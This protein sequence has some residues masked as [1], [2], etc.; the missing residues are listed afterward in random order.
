MPRIA[1]PRNG[2]QRGNERQHGR[3]VQLHGPL[4]QGGG[5]GAPAQDHFRERPQVRLDHDVG[6][7]AGILDADLDLLR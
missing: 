2:G 5:E 4:P 6:F 7:K 3:A 1:S